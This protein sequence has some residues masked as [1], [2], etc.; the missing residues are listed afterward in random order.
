MKAEPVYQIKYE[1]KLQ[2][3]RFSGRADLIGEEGKVWTVKYDRLR[4]FT[5]RL[6]QVKYYAEIC[7]TIAMK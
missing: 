3:F 6:L 1:V 7:S 4:Y 2:R 5:E